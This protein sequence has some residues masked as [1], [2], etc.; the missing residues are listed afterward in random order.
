MADI[1][2]TLF[3]VYGVLSA[4]IGARKTGQGAV[5]DFLFCHLAQDASS[6]LAH[7]A[8]SHRHGGIAR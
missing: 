5:G 3:A 2:C 7:C 1:G 4:Y 6:R 8:L